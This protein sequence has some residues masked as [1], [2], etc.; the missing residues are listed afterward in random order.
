LRTIL[1]PSE[2]LL[3]APT[4]TLER[5]GKNAANTSDASCHGPPALPEEAGRLRVALVG[6]PNVGKSV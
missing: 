4:D 6:N 5:S 3:N 2:A 1:N